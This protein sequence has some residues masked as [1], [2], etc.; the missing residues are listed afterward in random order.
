MRRYTAKRVTIHT[1]N[2]VVNY[3]NLIMDLSVVG[4][5]AD[6]CEIEIEECQ[7]LILRKVK[8]PTMDVENKKL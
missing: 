4:L 2:R 7:E 3:Y 1:G 6:N 8:D 5:S